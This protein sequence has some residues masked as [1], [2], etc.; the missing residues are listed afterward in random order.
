MKILRALRALLPRRG[1]KRISGEEMDKKL[2][3]MKERIAMSN[4]HKKEKQ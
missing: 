3:N 2:K 1:A 4:Q